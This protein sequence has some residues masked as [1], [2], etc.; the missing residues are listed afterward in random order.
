MLNLTFYE[1]G[2]QNPITGRLN[3]HQMQFDVSI[4]VSAYT[5]GQ[6]INMKIATNDAKTKLI[7]KFVVELIRVSNA[8]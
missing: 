3:E 6:T 8:E 5:P 2:F 4:P 7:S 1:F